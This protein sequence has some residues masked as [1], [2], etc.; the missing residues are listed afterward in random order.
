MQWDDREY[1]MMDRLVLWKPGTAMKPCYGLL[2]IENVVLFK[3]KIC[4][5]LHKQFVDVFRRGG[6]LDH[7]QALRDFLV[8]VPRLSVRD[9]E[10]CE[11]SITMVWVIARLRGFSL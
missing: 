2:L 11:G 7:G 8:D 4:E 3:V 1:V 5:A 6:K 10:C 9:A